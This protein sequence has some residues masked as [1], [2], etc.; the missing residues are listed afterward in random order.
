MSTSSKLEA[1]QRPFTEKQLVWRAGKTKPEKNIVQAL[2]DYRAQ[3][4]QDRLDEVLG[5]QNWSH[6]F[7]EVI[8]GGALVAVRC[9]LSLFIDGQWVGKEEVAPLPVSELGA[10]E[11]LKGAYANSLKRAAVHWGVGRYLQ[12]FSMWVAAHPSG[13]IVEAPGLPANMVPTGSVSAKASEQVVTEPSVQVPMETK[14]VVAVPPP[15]KAPVAA[16]EVILPTKVEAPL[17]QT[18]VSTGPTTEVAVPP[19]GT[20]SAEPVYMG[21][22]ELPS[23]LSEGE[24]KMV[25]DLLKRLSLNMPTLVLKDYLTGKGANKLGTA[26]K[27]YVFAKID[28]VEMSMKAAVAA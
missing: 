5:E 28:E 19:E 14:A 27:A 3:T 9:R 24:T 20:T 10:D 12:G 18:V 2:P 17:P 16:V 15:A 6:S 7:N 4:A 21:N 22:G 11:N 8:V 13:K 25:G 1:L 23:G 26:A